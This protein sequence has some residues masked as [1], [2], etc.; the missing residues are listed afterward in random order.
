LRTGRTRGEVVAGQQDSFFAAA[1]A[2][3]A[4][5]ARRWDE[6]RR[7]REQ[8]YLA[9]T[10]SGE[11]QRDE[12]DLAGGGY[13]HVALDL[14][15]ALRTGRSARLILDVPNG[16]SLPQL[17]PDVV[18]ELPCTVDAAGVRADPVTPL[19]LHQLGLVASV[20][21]AE[22]AVIEA[23][24]SGSRLAALRAFA[25]HPLV[26]SPRIAVELLTDVLDSSPELA[27]RLS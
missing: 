7:R 10:R 25:I 8:S 16:T 13:E 1:A 2:D 15:Q 11:E 20:R 14:I 22:R 27:A 21:A 4:G 23:V 12:A 17:P 19:D 6:A 9:E 5:A 3:P 18:V 26:G 24:T